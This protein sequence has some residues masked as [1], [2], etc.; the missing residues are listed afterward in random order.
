MN[1][2]RYCSAAAA[3]TLA[4]GAT[5]FANLGV[6][7]ADPNVCGGP[8]TPPCAGPS[9]LTP[10]QQCGLVAWQTWLPCNWLGVQVPVGTP[11]SL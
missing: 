6:A 2:I 11:G 5:T 8:A 3:I 9:P 1:R 4:I 10:E 7:S